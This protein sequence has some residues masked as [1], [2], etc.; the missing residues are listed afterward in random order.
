M[1]IAHGRGSVSNPVELEVEMK[2]WAWQHLKE[3]FH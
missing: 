2:Q 3:D 1:D